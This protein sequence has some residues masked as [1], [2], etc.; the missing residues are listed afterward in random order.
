MFSQLFKE[1]SRRVASYM[2][3]QHGIEK[4]PREWQIIFHGMIADY[5]RWHPQRTAGLENAAV[6]NLLYT[7]IFAG[8]DQP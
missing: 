5:R 7:E 4:T 2:A 1:S 3:G 6:W 8:K